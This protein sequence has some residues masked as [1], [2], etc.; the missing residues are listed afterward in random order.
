MT[1]ALNHNDLISYVGHTPPKCDSI[2]KKV[3]ILRRIF[4]AIY[5]SG[6]R[7]TDREIASFFARRGGHITDEFERELMHRLSTSNWSAFK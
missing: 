1:Y 7:R 5:E 6:R 3:G 4:D 2:V